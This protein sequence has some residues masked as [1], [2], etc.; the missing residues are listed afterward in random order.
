MIKKLLSFTLAGS[1]FL[2][3]GV[4]ASDFDNMTDNEKAQAVGVYVEEIVKYINDNYIGPEDISMEELM[5]IAIKSMAQSLDEYCDYITPEEYAQI[6]AAEQKVWYAPE[7]KCVFNEDGYP[8]ISE[9]KQNSKAYQAGLREG[10]T[11]RAIGDISAYG[12]GEEEYNTLVTKSDANYVKMKISSVDSVINEMNVPLMSIYNPTVESY[13]IADVAKGSESVKFD[14]KSIGYIKISTFSDKTAD[15]FKSAMDNLLKE[16]HT[17]LILDLRG[18]TGGY[19]EQAISIAQMIVPQGIIITTRD[20]QN[21]YK[22]YISNLKVTPFSKYV[23]LVDST[24]ASAAEI[25]AS[26]MQDSGIAKIVG[27]QTYGK[28]VMQSVV[29][30]NDAGVIKMTTE[31]YTTRNGNVIN[32]VGITPDVN[33]NKV[34]FVSEENDVNSDL[35]VA[36]M[37]FLGF[38]IDQNNSIE[39]A[40]GSYQAEMKIPVTYKLD[41]QTVNAINL[42][43]FNDMQKN[44]RILTAG[45]INIIS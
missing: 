6:K 3:S 9:I 8:Q 4:C 25:L 33:I 36:A 30:F 17:K 5:H 35:V 41:K 43:I 34:L 28:G 44:D 7:F 14:D 12:I 13:D 32:N 42:E 31:E 1:I 21:N 18:N 38:R 39:K 40:I 11:I 10:N 2:S 45:Y 20:K 26:A 23:V 27:E 22:N 15:E 16:N 24:T 19:V 29:D 37:K